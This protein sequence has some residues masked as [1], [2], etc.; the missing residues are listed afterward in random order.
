[1]EGRGEGLLQKRRGFN[2]GGNYAQRIDSLCLFN[3]FHSHV[4]TLSSDLDN[5]IICTIKQCH[6]MFILLLISIVIQVTQLQKS[7]V[8]LSGKVNQSEELLK[9]NENSKLPLV[10]ASRHSSCKKVQNLL[11]LLQQNNLIP[12]INKP[13]RVTKKAATAIDHM[14]TNCFVDTNF[15]TAIFKSDISDHI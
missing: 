10:F 7:K 5:T 11:N 3:F 4:V 15:K 9:N 14:I 13:T 6:T 8:E 1:M 2:P 12:V